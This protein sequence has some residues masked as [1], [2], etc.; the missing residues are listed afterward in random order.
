[1]REKRSSAPT[2]LLTAVGRQHDREF[3]DVATSKDGMS[4]SDVVAAAGAGCRPSVSNDM[5]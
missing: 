2:S 5:R 1:M 3:G 4:S